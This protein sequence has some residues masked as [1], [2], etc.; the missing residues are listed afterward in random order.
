MDEIPETWMIEYDYRSDNGPCHVGPFPSRQ[1]AIE[2]SRTLM[3]PGW[4]AE[5]GFVKLTPPDQAGHPS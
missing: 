4:Q 3:R 1:A 2:W 5:L